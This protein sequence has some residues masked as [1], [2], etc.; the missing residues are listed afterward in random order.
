[1][2]WRDKVLDTVLQAVAGNEMLF[3]MYAESHSCGG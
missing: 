2:S 1:M 3:Q